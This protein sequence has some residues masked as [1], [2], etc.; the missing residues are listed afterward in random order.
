MVCPCSMFTLHQAQAESTVLCMLLQLEPAADCTS[1]ALPGSPTPN[2][3]IDMLHFALQAVLALAALHALGVMHRDIKPDNM[4]LS[5][6][7]MLLLNDYDMSC[8]EADSAARSTL[9]VGT[10]AFMSPRLDSVGQGQYQYCD[11][12]LSLGLAFAYLVNLY[13]NPG[14]S[15]VKLDALQRLGQQEW[16]PACMAQA[17]QDP[18]EQ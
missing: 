3:L 9:P 7:G 5:S 16:C 12:W 8:T 2:A 15:S 18:M 10:P 1:A 6:G 17:L 4:L 11:D 13:P 14:D